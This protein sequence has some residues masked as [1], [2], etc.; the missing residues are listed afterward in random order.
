[1][2]SQGEARLG[3]VFLGEGRTSF[4]VWAPSRKTVEVALEAPTRAG[5]SFLPMER[6]GDG[7]FSAL[8]P[9]PAGTRYRYRLDGGD[10]FPD[11]CSRA[12][13]EGPHGPSEVVDPKRFRWTDQDWKAPTTKGQVFYELHVG[14]FT[15][16]GT[17]AALQRELPYFKELGV[18]TLELMPLNTF[19]GRFNWG[20]DGVSLFAPCPVYGTPDELRALVNEAHRVG[21]SIILDVVYNHLGPDGNHLAQFSRSYFSDDYPKEWGDPPNFDGKDSEHVREFFIQNAL[22]W[23]AEYHFDGLRLDAT[24]SLYDRSPRHVVADLVARARAQEKHRRICIVAENEP[25]DAQLIRSPERGGMGADAI[26][27]DDLHHTARVALTGRAEA[28]LSDYRGTAQELLSCALHNGIFQGQWYAWQKKGRGSLLMNE[29]AQ[30]MVVFLQNHDQIA[31][32]LDGARLHQLGGETRTR[33]LTTFLLLLPQTPLLF[34]GQEFFASSPFLFFTEHN[35]DLQRAVDKG[36]GEFLSQMPSVSQALTQGGLRL[37]AGERAFE[38]S[39]LNLDERRTHAGA[40]LLHQTLL[41]LRREDPLF[42]AQGEGVRVRGATLS[43][44]ALVLRYT[45]D[46]RTGERLVLLNLGVDLTLSICPEPLL[47]PVPG[48]GWTPLLSSEELRFGGRG[49]VFPSG[50]G[51]RLMPGHTAVVLTS[52]KAKS[53]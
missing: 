28:Y 19:P 36:R 9:V 51:P 50:E 44:E 37:D 32:S 2:K 7:Y 6:S 10:S 39:R 18:T 52:N 20:Y 4:R 46:D 1:V 26:W 48:R 45:G 16:Q 14:T 49:G 27:M 21:I 53:P 43:N 3:A 23:L 41:A 15:P 24:H 30:Q 25:Q 17:Y 38:R 13:P 40:L 35:P 8:H 29:P 31:N 34:M 12:Q 22:H 47:A 33:A 42:A 11:P 5:L